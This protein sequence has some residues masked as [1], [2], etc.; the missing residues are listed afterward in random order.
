MNLIP[1]ERYTLAGNP[2]TPILFETVAV[3]PGIGVSFMFLLDDGTRVPLNEAQL[4]G[5]IQRYEET[6]AGNMVINITTVPTGYIVCLTDEQENGNQHDFF[7][8]KPNTKIPQSFA[9]VTGFNGALR[10]VDLLTK[11][12][13]LPRVDVVRLDGIPFSAADAVKRDVFED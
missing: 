6:P 12:L 11:N 1:N 4:L 3:I 13:S 8:M 2:D 7:V 5:G 9:A 10:A